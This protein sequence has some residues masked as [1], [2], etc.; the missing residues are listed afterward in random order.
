ME[1]TVCL[2]I[3]TLGNVVMRQRALSPPLYNS[4]TPPPPPEQWWPPASQAPQE[5]YTSEPTLAW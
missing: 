5:K 2:I 3:F 4:P 1:H